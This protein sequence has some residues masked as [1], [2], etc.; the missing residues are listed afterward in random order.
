VTALGPVGSLQFT[1]LAAK[2]GIGCIQ[3]ATDV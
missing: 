3:L 1:H 2:V